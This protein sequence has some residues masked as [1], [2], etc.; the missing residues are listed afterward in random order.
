LARP[1]TQ[2]RAQ[3]SRED[4]KQV[5]HQ[6]ISLNKQPGQSF[7][8][9]PFFPQHHAWQSRGCSAGHALH[10]RKTYACELRDRR[11]AYEPV[12]IVACS[13]SDLDRV[14]PGVLPVTVCIILLLALPGLL[15]DIRGSI[16]RVLVALRDANVHALDAETHP[17]SLNRPHVLGERNTNFAVAK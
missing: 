4:Q 6:V 7:F 11:S 17:H 5:G 8:K 15:V 12:G 10:C 1:Q 9:M 2:R 14:S 3:C 16:A 13:I